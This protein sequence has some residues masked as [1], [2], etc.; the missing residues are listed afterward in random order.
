[1]ADLSVPPSIAAELADIKRRLRA[2]E[3]APQLQNSSL[4]GGKITALNDDE[5][6]VA[7]F[8][9][10]VGG[11]YGIAINDADTLN[12]VLL[13]NDENGMRAP[14]VP[15]AFRDSTAFLAVTS[16]TFEL[17]YRTFAAILA[18]S[19]VEVTVVLATDVGTTGEVRMGVQGG[20]YAATQSIGSG[21][22]LTFNWGWLHGLG[23]GLGSTGQH[24]VIEAR[25]TGGAGNVYVFQPDPLLDIYA[26]SATSTG[27]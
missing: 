4:T 14:G 15:W 17:T 1:M 11:G 27:V 5:Q 24:F 21:A 18:S 19:S 3:G 26:P 2:M 20:P 7:E 13:V 8:G 12:S 9:S 22:N 25:R 23:F 16:G 10:L 6:R